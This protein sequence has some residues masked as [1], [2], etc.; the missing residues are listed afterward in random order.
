MREEKESSGRSSPSRGP[1]VRASPRSSS[2]SS[3]RPR[4][5]PVARVEAGMKVRVGPELWGRE[6]ESRLTLTRIRAPTATA[7]QK[8]APMS[9]AADAFFDAC[10]AMTIA[11]I[12]ARSRCTRLALAEV[13]SG[14]RAGSQRSLSPQSSENCCRELTAISRPRRCANAPPV[15]R[16][17]TRASESLLSHVHS[18]PPPRRSRM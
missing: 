5:R 10:M 9:T 2:R 1:C 17:H 16:S 7:S 13:P 6:Q 18:R 4:C 15:R 12:E 14:Q 8:R 11:G 3:R